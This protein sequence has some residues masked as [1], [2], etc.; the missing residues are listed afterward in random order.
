MNATAG[1][2]GVV[3]F[4]MALENLVIDVSGAVT[5][6]FPPLDAATV[7]VRPER[8]TGIFRCAYPKAVGVVCWM[9]TGYQGTG[10]VGVPCAHEEFL[11]GI[12]VRVRTGFD[13]RGR[14]VELVD[15]WIVWRESL[16]WC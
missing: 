1:L 4:Q 9:G 15:L 7:D 2:P 10:I 3:L 8:K 5:V 11:G 13:L 16:K 12:Q 6:I 14:P